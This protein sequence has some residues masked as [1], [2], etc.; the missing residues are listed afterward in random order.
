MMQPK[1]SSDA[2]RGR[3]IGVPCAE[4]LGIAS[5]G[6]PTVPQ[7]RLWRRVASAEET[8]DLGG[9]RTTTHRENRVAEPAANLADGIII[10]KPDLLKSSKGISREHLRPLVA[11][12]ARAVAAAEDVA[13]AAEEAVIRQRRQHGEALGELLLQLEGRLLA[14]RVVVVVQRHV[15]RTK[16]ELPDHTHA[17]LEGL[18]RAQLVEEVARKWL[19]RGIVFGE[20]RAVDS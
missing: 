4:T 5:V 3:V 18:L 10:L 7:Q 16:V 8:E 14:V 20:A 13:K 9:V 12:V 6:Q 17:R 15:E 2:R 11:V 1:L 19:A